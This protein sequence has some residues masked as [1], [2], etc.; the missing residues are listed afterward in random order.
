MFLL[1]YLLLM[2][3]ILWIG[4]YTFNFGRWCLKQKNLI[5]AIFVFMLASA[6]VAIPSF[7]LIFGPIF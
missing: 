7:L 6:C 1:K 3:V 4:L 5:G 2:P